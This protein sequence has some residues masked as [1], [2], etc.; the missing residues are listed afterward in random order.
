MIA[1]KAKKSR[2][3]GNLETIHIVIMIPMINIMNIKIGFSSIVIRFDGEISDNGY[4]R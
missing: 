4:Y 1:Y 3:R 2:K